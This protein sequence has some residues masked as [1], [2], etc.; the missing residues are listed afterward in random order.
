MGGT[1]PTTSPSTHTRPHGKTRTRSVPEPAVADSGRARPAARPRRD[2]DSVGTAVER[3][4][5]ADAIG[6]D[7]IGSDAIGGD[8]IGSDAIGGD[9]N[10]GDTIGSDA[11]GGDALAGGADGEAAGGVASIAWGGRV[12]AAAGGLGDGATAGGSRLAGRSAE[13]RG[14]ESWAR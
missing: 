14:A 11:I 8:T 2:V 12:A 3:F 9:A 13:R 5:G 1:E 6:G 7:T 10:G 4:G